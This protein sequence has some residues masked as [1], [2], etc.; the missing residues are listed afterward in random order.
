MYRTN[1]KRNKKLMLAYYDTKMLYYLK[2]SLIVFL[3]IYTCIII[4]IIRWAELNDEKIKNNIFGDWDI[5]FIDVNIEDLMYFQKHAFIKDYF[6]QS[7]Q[8]KVHLENNKSVII[9]SCDDKFIN[10]SN[11]KIIDGKMP[12]H[13]NE[14]AIEEEYLSILGVNEVGDII[15][16]DS[17]VEALR[18]YKVC[19]I[20]SNYSTN[21]HTVNWKLNLVNCFVK[22]K[23]T[24]EVN[25]FINSDH[26]VQKDLI[27]NNINYSQN[28]EYTTG[29]ILNEII[30]IWFIVL[31]IIFII[32]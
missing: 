5:V 31:I 11:I 17:M 16:N 7:I 15:P 22:D 32:F 30:K 3:I 8:E 6:V 20:M 27:V 26:I 9:G 19:G 21:W 4:F 2:V 1:K 23:G 29:V 12:R 25:I 24:K 14:V 10:L 28:I 13:S 18:G